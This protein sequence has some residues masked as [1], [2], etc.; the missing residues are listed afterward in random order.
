MQK[1]DTG[2]VTKTP[3]RMAAKVSDPS[4]L[5][6]V[7]QRALDKL[8]ASARSEM[9]LTE[10]EAVPDHRTR[11]TNGGWFIGN[12]LGNVDEAT[13]NNMVV[14]RAS[15]DREDLVRSQPN[16][17]WQPVAYNFNRWVQNYQTG[18]SGS[19]T[20]HP[21]PKL[22]LTI[23]WMDLKNEAEIKYAGGAPVL[24][25][26]TTIV[27]EQG[28]LADVIRDLKSDGEEK[29]KALSML[30]EA[31]L[32]NQPTLPTVPDKVDDAPPVAKAK[33]KARTRK[34]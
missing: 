10:G 30:M 8:I 32:A 16:G 22:L 15:G 17:N 2:L 20:L 25:N 29:S 19:A 12:L 7:G 9:G 3:N 31:F 4:V 26:Q 21:Q 11:L 6:S 28:G 1:T 33:A 27:K 18:P 13:F 24:Q 14:Y 34:G 5:M 23:R